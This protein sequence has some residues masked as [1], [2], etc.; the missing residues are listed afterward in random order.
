ML[1]LASLVWHELDSTR[2]SLSDILIL[3]L[4]AVVH[5]MPFWSGEKLKERLPA[6]VE[7]FETEAI[8]C[9][10]Y[11]LHVGFE[12][13]ISPD[14]K[15]SDSNRHTKQKLSP[16]QAFTIPPGQFGFVMTSETVAV[17]DD[18]LAFISI[19]ARMKFR[20]LINISGFHVD[21]GYRGQL[22]FSVWN[23]GPKPLHLEQGQPLFLIWFADLDR[24]TDSKK[25]RTGLNSL[26]PNFVNGISGE[27][28]S[29]Q[30]LSDEH[31]ELE[32]RLDD[33]FQEQKSALSN[34]RLET[35]ITRGIGIALL[36][37]LGLWVL[38]ALS[39]GA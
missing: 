4:V 14:S 18:A 7:P 3:G 35:Q 21:P 9:A 28:L 37:G 36:I 27:I 22:L 32:K 34:L 26:E 13:Y 12:V 24:V 33:Q 5:K 31:R 11:T 2:D 15:I 20:G 1:G 6:L 29:L 30:A 10:A 17:P 25:D 16:S 19:K 39:D 8:D 23:A 38:R